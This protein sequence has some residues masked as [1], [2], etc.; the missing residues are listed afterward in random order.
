MDLQTTA[1]IM[2]RLVE[3]V[4]E[5]QEHA[6]LF[7]SFPILLEHVCRRPNVETSQAFYC[8][9]YNCNTQEYI[10]VLLQDTGS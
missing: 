4:D 8:R 5:R 6:E 1:S 3:R 7:H 9:D 2:L 10:H